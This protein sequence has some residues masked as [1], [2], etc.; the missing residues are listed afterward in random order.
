MS[1]KSVVERIQGKLDTVT[2]RWWLYP[3]ILLLFFI[4]SYASKGYDQ[5]ESLDLI[6]QALSDP[7]IY[8]FPVLMPIAKAIPAVLIAG[9]IVLGNRIRRVFN[10][11]VA[12]LYVALACLQTTAQTGTYGFVL[13]SGNLALVLVVALVWI[14]E[15]VA[16][17]NDFTPQRQPLWKWWVVPLAIVAFLAPVDASTMSPDF[18]PVRL[19]T[20]ES[21]L[22]YCMMTPVILAVLTLF[23]PSVN[24][25]VLR[26]SSFVGIIFGAVNMAVWFFVKPSGWWMGVL[27]IPLLV[28]SVYAFVLA[29]LRVKRGTEELQIWSEN[30]PARS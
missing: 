24:R 1:T 10:G 11:Y 16:E 17:R 7:L 25:A 3:L 29:H 2:K 28:V 6:G 9:L 18:S 15:V 8:T 13:L 5:R 22:T 12:F 19:L 4:P 20:N 23:H 27:H 21:G 14:W 30:R 26:V